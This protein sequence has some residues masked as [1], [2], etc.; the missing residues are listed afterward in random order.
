MYV[1]K[2]G[3]IQTKWPCLNFHSTKYLN[4]YFYVRLINPKWV[5]HCK[6]S[7]CKSIWIRWHKFVCMW[8]AD[9]DLSKMNSGVKKKNTGRA[10][11][12]F[13]SSW[14]A[15]HALDLSSILRW[16]KISWGGKYWH[17]IILHWITIH[18]TISIL[19]W[20]AGSCDF[21]WCTTC[22][23]WTNQESI[24]SIEAHWSE[25]FFCIQI[26]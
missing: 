14:A 13:W 17:F 18:C 24:K 6:R 7:L 2:L 9:I 26:C 8:F 22:N 10:Y 21:W 12:I 11:F 4:V 19:L 5:G 15:W 3:S 1:W 20:F 23:G 16:H 25:E